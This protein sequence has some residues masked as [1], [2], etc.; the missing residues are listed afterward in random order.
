MVLAIL[1]ILLQG[2]SNRDLRGWWTNSEDGQSY[3]VLEDSN[4]G[5]CPP[6]FIDRKE[7]KAVIGSKVQISAGS[8]S[9]TCGT[10]GNID[11]KFT[12]PPSAIYHFD[13]WGP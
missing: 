7:V 13:Y 8:H 6:V 1:P 5:N 12:V 9:I 2:C 10:E 11:V 4:G 3:F